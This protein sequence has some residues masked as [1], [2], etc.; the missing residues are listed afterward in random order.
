ME[1]GNMGGLYAKQLS[2]KI[3]QEQQPDLAWSD[4]DGS[5]PSLVIELEQWHGKHGIEAA[6]AWWRHHDEQPVSAAIRWMNAGAFKGWYLSDAAFC[7]DF[8]G[9]AEGRG[10]LNDHFCTW[11]GKAAGFTRW[12]DL[13]PSTML[14]LFDWEEWAHQA[15]NR[16][17]AAFRSLPGYS[18]HLEDTTSVF[19][20][21]V[22]GQGPAEF[23]E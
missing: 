14:D 1:R 8:Y 3:I 4:W 15:M 5:A 9:L 19:V 12:P 13:S 10:S 23:V 18:R 20:W 6:H 17:G 21:D 11:D 16:K 22:T 2:W 7:R